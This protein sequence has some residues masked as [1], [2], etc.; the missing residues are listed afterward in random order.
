MD[1]FGFRISEFG[2]WIF[3]FAIRISKLRKKWDTEKHRPVENRR[4]RIVM[5][6]YEVNAAW[7]AKVL[8]VL[9]S[10]FEIRI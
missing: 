10:K 5:V 2:F 3:Q 4:A 1:D 6:S 9:I 8:D 7:Q